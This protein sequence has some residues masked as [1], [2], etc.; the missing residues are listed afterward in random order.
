MA[1][2]Y[3]IVWDLDGT[4]GDF[5]AL[6]KNR[7]HDNTITVSIR[8]GLAEALQSLSRAG[9]VHSLLTMATPR[10]AEIALRGTGLY[11]YFE[12]VEGQGQRRKGDVDGLAKVFGIPPAKMP[13]QILFVGDRMVFDEP[14]HPDVIFH[15]ELFALKRPASDFERLVLQLRDVGNGSLRHGFRRLS[16]SDRKWYRFWKRDRP[17]LGQPIQKSIDGL[18]SL[19]LLERHEECPVIAF[20]ATPSSTNSAHEHCFVPS[21]VVASYD[22]EFDEYNDA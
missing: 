13:S 9:F 20:E 10:Y 14:R 17:P 18:G 8:P 4:L 5:S 12:R 6:E 15:L 19:I 22:E 1:I 2:P 11:D 16:L 3:V 7:N 21:Q